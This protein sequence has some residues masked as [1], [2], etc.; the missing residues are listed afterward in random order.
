M[1]LPDEKKKKKIADCWRLSQIRCRHDVKSTNSRWETFPRSSCILFHLFAS[2]WK[3]SHPLLV[4]K[5][6]RINRFFFYV[7]VIFNQKSWKMCSILLSS[8]PD[9]WRSPLI[10]FFSQAYMSSSPEHSS[11]SQKNEK[12]SKNEESP[13]TPKIFILNITFHRWIQTWQWLYKFLI[14]L[15]SMYKHIE[16]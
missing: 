9:L 5:N 3:A 6:W 13:N 15:F 4:T 2:N 12:T 11:F 8:V 1:T 14:F 7:K 16:E 10:M